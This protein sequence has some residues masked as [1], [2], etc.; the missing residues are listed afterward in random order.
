MGQTGKFKDNLIDGFCLLLQAEGASQG[1]IAEVRAVLQQGRD[2]PGSELER[3]Q[4]LVKEETLEKSRERLAGGFGARSSMIWRALMLVFIYFPDETAGL[5]ELRR[6]L[7]ILTRFRQMLI[8]PSKGTTDFQGSY[9]DES[10]DLRTIFG[11]ATE[12]YG[13]LPIFPEVVGTLGEVQDQQK[14]N[15][16]LHTGCA[17]S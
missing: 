15:K 16:F 9:A 13:V 14:T 8:D 4:K 11:R 5:T 6:Q 17:S 2:D 7:R 1:E 3:L 10:F 12:S